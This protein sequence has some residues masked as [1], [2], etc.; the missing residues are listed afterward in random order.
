LDRNQPFSFFMIQTIELR[1]ANVSDLEYLYSIHRACMKS[2]VQQVWGWDEDWQKKDFHKWFARNRKQ[3][4]Q[5]EEADVGY[6]EYQERADGFFL[7]N[8]MIA[9]EH[10]GK[11]IGSYLIRSLIEQAEELRTTVTLQ[12]LKVNKRALALYFR[13]GFVIYGANEHHFLMKYVEEDSAL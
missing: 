12:V 7:G 11:G 13:L 9:P 3:V 10:Q 5:V 2:Y 8:I 4:I 6:W 1:P